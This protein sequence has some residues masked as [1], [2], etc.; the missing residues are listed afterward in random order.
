MTKSCPKSLSHGTLLLPVFLV[1]FP[2]G[3][4]EFIRYDRADQSVKS[5]LAERGIDIR[6]VFVEIVK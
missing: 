4:E 6:D 5:I 1:R 3:T 2:D